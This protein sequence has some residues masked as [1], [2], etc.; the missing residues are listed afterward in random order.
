MG[1]QFQNPFGFNLKIYFFKVFFSVIYLAVIAV[2]P[3]C[4][5]DCCNPIDPLSSSRAQRPHPSTGQGNGTRLPNDS[6]DNMQAP[7]HGF[8][9]SL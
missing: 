8:T 7:R 1:E 3:R 9:T 4:L 5:G 2:V 6:Q